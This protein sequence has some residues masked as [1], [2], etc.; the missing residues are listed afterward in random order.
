M[1]SFDYDLFTI[2]AGSGGVRAS[3][4]AA[5]QGARVA[6]AEE[7]REGG[8]CVLRGCVPKKLFVLASHYAEDFNDAAGFGWHVGETSFD[9]PT[10]R[11]R[12]QAML[13]RLSGVYRRNLNNAGAEIILDRAVVTG[14]NSVRLVREGRDVTAEK[15]LVASGSWPFLPPNVLG[16][17]HAISSNE[18]FLLETLPKRMVIV[19]GG[20]IA[21]EFACIMHGLGVDVTL[22]YR[23]TEILRG[24]DLDL[25]V[26]LRREMEHKGIKVLIE[27]DVKCIEKEGDGYVVI[28]DRDTEIPTDLVFYATGRLP[29]TNGL[30]LETAGVELRENGAIVVDEYSKT[31]C[32]S[33]YAIGD[34]TDRVNLTPVAIREGIAFVETVFKNN[35]TKPDYQC[36]P[37]A[38]FSQPPIGTV[39][40]TEL[41]AL[42]AGTEYD[43]YKTHFRTMKHSFVDRDEHMLMKLIVERGTDRVLGCHLIGADAPEMIQMVGIAVRMGATKAQFDATVAV[44]P[45]S[46]EELV[47]IRE[48][49]VP[50]EGDP[51]HVRPAAASR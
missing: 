16:I 19:G 26:M 9:W 24:F 18:M 50:E 23:G 49:F 4:L 8:T 13:T 41:E 31:T 28:L 27:S 32:D 17:E 48:P 7:D 44:H 10:L 42:Q 40:I 11:E 29:L 1:T 6:V 35:P 39:G 43:I 46:A 30:G 34:V 45:T 25:R 12:V 21:V 36:I 22:I 47:T 38:V 33:I 15:I 2:G 14:P 37:T 20:Y 5:Q 51:R 3:R